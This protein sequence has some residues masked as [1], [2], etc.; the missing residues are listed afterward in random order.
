MIR[1]TDEESGGVALSFAERLSW[2][3]DVWWMVGP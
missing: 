1:S 3:V 2:F